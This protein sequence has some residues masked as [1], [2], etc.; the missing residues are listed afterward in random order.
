MGTF[1]YSFVSLIDSPATLETIV[2]SIG[3]FSLC[4]RFKQLKK[5][6]E[7][8]VTKKYKRMYLTIN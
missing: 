1:A 4:E 2:K 6:A 8:K 7:Y 3:N 5:S